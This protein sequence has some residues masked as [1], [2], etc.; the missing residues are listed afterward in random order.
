MK[1]LKKYKIKVKFK[2]F[3]K[4]LKKK[5]YMNILRYRNNL[6]VSNSRITYK[7]YY[8]KKRYNQKV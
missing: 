3:K 1:F 5:F 4:K 2:K 7:M 6:I 8:H